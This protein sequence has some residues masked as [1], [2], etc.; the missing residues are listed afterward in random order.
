MGFFLFFRVVFLHCEDTCKKRLW[1]L[2]FVRQNLSG[3][4]KHFV[5]DSHKAKPVAP[6]GLSA[7]LLP[8]LSSHLPRVEPGAKK[9]K[10]RK[11]KTLK[12]IVFIFQ[13]TFTKEEP[14]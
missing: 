3:V 12:K 13:L 14:C 10:R 6:C 2:D 5:T 7:A 4:S 8:L 1:F 11:N 9:R